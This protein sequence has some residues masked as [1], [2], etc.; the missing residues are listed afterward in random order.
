M[1]RCEGIVTAPPTARQCP[2]VQWDAAASE[3]NN[4]DSCAP[5][6]PTTTRISS[7][8]YPSRQTRGPQWQL[9]E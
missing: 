3:G 1:A 6:E 4:D 9:R 2:F 5:P 7:L 8:L